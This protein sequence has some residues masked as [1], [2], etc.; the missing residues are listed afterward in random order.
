MVDEWLNTLDT[1]TEARINKEITKLAMGN[2]GDY[3]SVGDGIL[4]KRI[5]FGSGYRLY[6]K[7][8]DNELIILFCGGDKRTQ[9]QDIKLAK[10]LV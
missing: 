3:N 6:F 10:S 7:I 1:R 4:E 2:F 5:H 9:K 8:E